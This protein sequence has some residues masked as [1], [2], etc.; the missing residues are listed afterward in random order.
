MAF[1][2]GFLR[3]TQLCTGVGM[4]RGKVLNMTANNCRVPDSFDFTYQVAPEPTWHSTHPTRACGDSWYAVNSGF[5][6]EWQV[7]PQNCTES[8]NS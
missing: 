3:W 6:T 1:F 4:G 5:I 8:V 2:A 7:C